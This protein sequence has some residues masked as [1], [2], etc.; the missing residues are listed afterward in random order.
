MTT[1]IDY[2]DLLYFLVNITQVIQQLTMQQA[3]GDVLF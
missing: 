1:G 3:V 2:A